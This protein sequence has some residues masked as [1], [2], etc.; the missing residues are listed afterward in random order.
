MSSMDLD[1]DPNSVEVP[2]GHHIGGRF[3]DLAGDEIAVLRPSDHQPMGVIRDG[4]GAAVERA[5]E[6][7]GRGLAESR[8]AKV[9]PRERGTVLRRWADLVERDR[10]T[11]ARL[12]A[13]GSTRP[14]AE[15]LV[16]D[17]TRTAEVIRFYGEYC[18]KIEGQ[19][20][21]T[22][23]GVLSLVRREPY[24]IVAAVVPWNFPMITAAWKFA[25]ALAA[26]NAIIMKTSELTPFSLL[27][28]A[29][30]AAE[31]GMPAGL[32]NVVNGLG[33]TT[34]S[35]LVR[36]PEIR[37]ISFTGSTGTGARLMVD[38]AM[39]GIKP[40]TLE[41]GG[42]S[43]QLVF[44]D[45][46]DL[47]TVAGHVARG[48]LGNAGQVCTA[49]SRLIVQRGIADALLDKVEV[50]CR[51]VHA[52]PTWSWAT[53]FSPIVSARQL[54][55][56][57]GLVRKTIGE[58]ARVRLGGHR[59]DSNE[60]SFYAP[61]ILEGVTPDMTGFREEFFG[62]VLSVHRFDDPEE[63]IALS[64]H[65]IYGLAASVYTT[66]VRKALQAAD[67]IEAGMVWINHHGRAPEFTFP[68]GGFKGSGFG[69]DMGRQGIE[70]FMREKA[71]WLNYQ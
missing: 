10:V 59:L 68:A 63:G 37:K 47:D 32:L 23:D 13:T 16:R 22:E 3:V 25:P 60:G 49:G 12:E 1:F 4:G 56:L 44:D 38:A 35:A 43:P 41:L 29:D 33:P 67:A 54:D 2:I 14:I 52:G 19:V 70:G 36:H 61:T 20:T 57:D 17:A 24:G 64:G 5:V 9:S 40:V 34:G 71:V 50:H 6:A 26:G 7:A 69:K 30:L 27:A 62:P 21:A 51:A 8:W 11:L 53:T 66:D 39:S 42:K 58:G 28:L 55:R 15:T 18:D 65:P 31:A 46:G 48:F 45:P